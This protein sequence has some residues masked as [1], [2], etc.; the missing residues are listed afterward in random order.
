MDGKRGKRRRERNTDC[1]G[2]RDDMVAARNW[3]HGERPL[4]CTDHRSEMRSALS[5]APYQS[6]VNPYFVI[7]SLQLRCFSFGWHPTVGIESDKIK[8]KPHPKQVP[9]RR[10]RGM[11]WS[12]VFWGAKTMSLHSS[13]LTPNSVSCLYSKSKIGTVSVG[14]RVRASASDVPD[15]LSADWYAIYHACICCV[16]S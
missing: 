3:K 4:I 8:S 10:K 7:L 6:R 12:W 1:T 5:N 14:S 2:K 11:E 16:F 15:F 9:L 13:L